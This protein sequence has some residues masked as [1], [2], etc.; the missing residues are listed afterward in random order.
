MDKNFN[1][2]AV[3]LEKKI[4][5]TEK[6]HIRFNL[7]KEDILQFCPDFQDNTLHILD[8]GGGT[9]KFSRFCASKGHN[10]LHCDI[11]SE[12]L[13]QAEVENNK[14]HYHKQIT[15]LN[16]DLTRITNDAYGLFDMV[17]LHG[18]A[19]WM[20]HPEDAIRYCISLLK[21][22]AAISLLIY[23]K[24]KYI[25]KRGVNGRLLVKDKVN[26]KSRK[27]TP[28]GKMSPMEIIDVLNDF[29]GELVLQS[30]IR[31]FNHFLKIIEPLSITQNEWLEQERLYYRK[32]PFASLGEHTHILWRKS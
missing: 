14:K 3:R 30:G 16:I 32:E 11:S 5:G 28:T 17:L 1:S 19:E 26:P 22:G 18:V 2:L 20:T 29:K 21:P 8:A 15:L 27:L 9:G 23:N 7:L 25:L 12:M 31:V 24:N 6:G 13:K 10:V 4:Y